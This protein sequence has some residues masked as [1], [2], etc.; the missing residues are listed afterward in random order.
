MVKIKTR[1]L[2][3]KADVVQNINRVKLEM[4][5]EEDEFISQSD[6]IKK[7]F[8]ETDNWIEPKSNPKKSKFSKKKRESRRE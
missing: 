4:L 7:L 1:T 2:A 6:V 5:N 3:I 8:I